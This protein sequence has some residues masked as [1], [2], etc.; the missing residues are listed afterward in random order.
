MLISKYDSYYLKGNEMKFQRLSLSMMI[1]A[2]I[3]LLTAC[4]GG[5]DSGPSDNDFIHW[6]N[7]D[8]PNK[9]IILDFNNEQFR[10]TKDTR[11]IYGE[12]R[13]RINLDWCNK[14]GDPSYLILAEDTYIAVGIVKQ[15]DGRCLAMFVDPKTLRIVD[16]LDYEKGINGAFTNQIAVLC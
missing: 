14:E 2:L 1:A 10:L 11:C 6:T 8:N 16:I 13:Q 3:G 7:S 4:G 5:G 12:A 9:T 15:T